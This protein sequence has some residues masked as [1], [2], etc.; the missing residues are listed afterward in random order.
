MRQGHAESTQTT[1]W[2]VRGEQADALDADSDGDGIPDSYEVDQGLKPL[3]LDGDEDLDLDGLSNL[4]EF[5]AGTLANDSNSVFQI[6]GVTRPAPGGISVELS[7]SSVTG[8]TYRL[9]SSSTVDGPPV[10]IGSVVAT[11]T[12]TRMTITLQALQA[13]VRAE[14]Q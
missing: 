9:L 10:D 12:E 2:D 13:F 6:S 4:R 5:W 14:V 7:F 11:N 8:R 1:G 3:L